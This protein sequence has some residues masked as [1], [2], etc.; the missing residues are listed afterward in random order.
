MLAGVRGTRAALS[1]G[2][3]LPDRETSMAPDE[4]VLKFRNNAQ[5]VIPERNIDAAVE[6][7]LNLESVADIGTVMGLFSVQRDT[8]GEPRLVALA[9]E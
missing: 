6:A 3:S 9:G 8:V 7:V 1:K 5:G 2:Q 4:L